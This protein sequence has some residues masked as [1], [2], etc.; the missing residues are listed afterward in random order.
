[1]STSSPES[2][3]S[4]AAVC[5]DSGVTPPVTV[6]APPPVTW[7]EWDHL[8]SRV[9]ALES[10]L[11]ALLTDGPASRLDHLA[12][13]VRHIPPHQSGVDHPLTQLAAAQTL[14][15]LQRA[16]RLKKQPTW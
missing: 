7:V 12:N 14:H 5:A 15:L 3:P 8:R 2:A 16:N 9:V 13:V 1:M 4:H 10:L 6:S 11:V